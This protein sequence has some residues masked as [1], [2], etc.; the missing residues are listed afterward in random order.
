VTCPEA[1][2][3]QTVSRRNPDQTEMKQ[4]FLFYGEVISGAGIE[5]LAQALSTC[6]WPIHVKKSGCNGTLYLQ[7][8]GPDEIDIRMDSGQSREFVFSGDGEATLERAV[9]LIGD[10]S[11]KLTAA[12]FLHRVE[13]YNL[14]DELVGYFHHR[15]PQDQAR[16]N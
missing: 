16:P 12:S 15:W 13:L 9:E 1:S 14:A 6:S 2:A 5:P 10:F 3:V 8:T 4:E 7:T 11:Q